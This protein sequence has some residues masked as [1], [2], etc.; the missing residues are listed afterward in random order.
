MQFCRRGRGGS[1][2]DRGGG[3]RS[4]GRGRA[5]ALLLVVGESF[6]DF[7]RSRMRW[8]NEGFESVRCWRR[9]RRRRR[10]RERK[11]KNEVSLEEAVGVEPSARLEERLMGRMAFQ[12]GPFLPLS[13]IAPLAPTPRQ[14]AHQALLPIGGGKLERERALNVPCEGPTTSSRRRRQSGGKK[15]MPTTPQARGPR[16]GATLLHWP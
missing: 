10:S 4:D 5:A 15:E 16:R 12:L 13:V 11:N 9:R 8:G 14:G 2:V 6:F 7:D 1:G 3:R